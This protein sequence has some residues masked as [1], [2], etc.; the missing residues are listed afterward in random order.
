MQM[1]QAKL[2]QCQDTEGEE[3]VQL[4]GCE[5]QLWALGCAVNAPTHQ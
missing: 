4:R 1:A 2:P 5:E 3:L